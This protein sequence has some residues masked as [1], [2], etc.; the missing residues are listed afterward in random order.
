MFA[1]AAALHLGFS[2]EQIISYWQTIDYRLDQQHLEGLNRF[3]DLCVG[4]GLLEEVPEI[5][6]L[7]KL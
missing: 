6:F 4:Y 3:F 7:A 2:P 1:E 5:R